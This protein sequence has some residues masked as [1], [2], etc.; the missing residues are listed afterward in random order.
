M[1]TSDIVMERVQAL[2]KIDSGSGSLYDHLVQLARKLADEKPAE[3]LAQ[4]ETLSRHLKQSTFRGVSGADEGLPIVQDVPAEEFR[5]QFCE[6]VL[7]LVKAPE[8]TVAPKVLGNVR[9]F[10][11]DSAMFSWA[12]VG[13]SQQESYHLAMSLRKLASE[14]PSIVQLR[15]WG[16]ILGLEGDY[17]V[18]EGVL[19]TKSAPVAAPPALPGTAEY[20]VEPRGEGA[21]SF[22]YWVASGSCAPW[23]R[24]PSARASH[25]VAARAI[26]HFLTGNLDAPVHSMPWFPGKERHLLRAQIARISATCV[27][28][29]RGWYEPDDAEGAPENKI[30]VVEDPVADFVPAE[31]LVTEAG[32]VHASPPLLNVGKTTIPDPDAL[33]ETASEEMKEELTAAREAE[34]EGFPMGVLKEIGADLED[35]KPEGSEEGSPAWSIKTFGDKGVYNSPDPTSHQVVAVRSL[36]WPGAVACA[37]GKK[38][39][40]IYIGYGM[41]SGTLVPRSPTSGLPLRNTSP[42]QPLEPAD[43]CEEPADLEE[44]DEPNPQEDDNESDK[45]SVDGEE[46][47]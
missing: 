21:N 42:F 31:E 13:F 29:T 11:E 44:H 3:A 36:I 37:Q 19:E 45:G 35:M 24:L 2:L 6:D 43:I 9:N 34:G 5:M 28:A 17:Y 1:G 12:G 10:L 15:L 4:I 22:T 40:N 16:K 7:K 47:G 33:P 23:V 38:F 18:A 8:P 14:T 41:K 26:K 25:V 27:L 20:D 46:E 30:R 39:A 32:W